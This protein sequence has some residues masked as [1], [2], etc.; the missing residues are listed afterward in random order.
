MVIPSPWGGL[1]KGSSLPLGRVREGLRLGRVRVGL[2]KKKL[3]E[4]VEPI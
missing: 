1:G 3:H 2:Y 4:T